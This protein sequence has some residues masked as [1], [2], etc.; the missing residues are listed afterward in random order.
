MRRHRT[1][2]RG[3]IFLAVTIGLAA[4]TAAAFAASKVPEHIVFPV[5][6]KAQ[7]IDDFGAPRAG[8]VRGRRQPD[9]RRILGTHL[10][11]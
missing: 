6:G 5:V 4:G 8:G 3:F 9:G 11:G 1:T 2:A 7:Y 10:P